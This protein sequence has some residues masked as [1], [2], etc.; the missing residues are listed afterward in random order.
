MQPWGA[1]GRSVTI[2]N[3]RAWYADAVAV[4]GDGNLWAEVVT[5]HTTWRT[6]GSPHFT[7]YGLTIDDT[8]TRLW[9]D[10]PTNRQDTA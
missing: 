9:L 10:D 8:G 4:Y 7:R 3:C 6:T 2:A 5:A 1:A